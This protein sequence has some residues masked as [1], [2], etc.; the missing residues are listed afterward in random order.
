MSS[1]TR[2]RRTVALAAGAL[3]L[4][5]ACGTPSAPPPPP[6]VDATAAAVDD[7]APQEEPDT[8]DAAV[9]AF[10]T[11]HVFPDGN[12][13]SVSAPLAGP[14]TAGAPFPRAVDVTVTVRNGTPA[15]EDLSRFGVDATVPGATEEA[16]DREAP[17]VD[18]GLS[19]TLAPGAER[20]VT[21]RFALPDA[22]P[23]D[24]TVEIAKADQSAPG[25]D[26]PGS[27]EVPGSFV[28]FEGRV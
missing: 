10:G 24:V 17:A 5:A 11:T 22:G 16:D 26:V 28:E 15:A 25:V 6:P 1:T 14:V 12:A 20:A 18:D 3:L 9:L 4:T 27:D 7:A 21:V 23:T 2:V 19:G 8:P 13:V